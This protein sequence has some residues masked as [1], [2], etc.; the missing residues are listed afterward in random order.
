LFFEL[1]APVPGDTIDGTG[2]DDTIAVFIAD[3][4]VSHPK[5][6]SPTDEVYGDTG[7]AA[8]RPVTCGGAY[9]NGAR[10][11]LDNVI[12]YASLADSRPAWR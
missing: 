10:S 2:A 7:H 8:L 9:G 3:R 1:G 4:V 6:R 11:Y 12:V 5:A